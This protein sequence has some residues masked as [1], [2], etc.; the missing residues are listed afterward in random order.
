M[1]RGSVALRED[2]DVRSATLPAGTW[3]SLLPDGGGYER[4]RLLE[5][6]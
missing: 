5:L 2:A 4:L 1:P 6:A 3:R